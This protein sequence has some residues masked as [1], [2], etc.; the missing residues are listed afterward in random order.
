MAELMDPKVSVREGKKILMEARSCLEEYPD[1]LKQFDDIFMK[2]DLTTT[3]ERLK[4]VSQMKE[5]AEKM[6]AE[7]AKESRR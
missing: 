3:V 7:E 6:V 4:S 5:T 1:I 2:G